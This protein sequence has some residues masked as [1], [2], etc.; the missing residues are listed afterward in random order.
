MH[1]Q[2]ILYLYL[3]TYIHITYYANY[4]HPLAA[5]GI[6]TFPS[7][8]YHTIPSQL[9]APSSRHFPGPALSRLGLVDELC[10]TYALH[11]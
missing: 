5:V 8:P 4:T 7:Q 9:P 1:T 11:P 6:M 2:S 10:T 3:H